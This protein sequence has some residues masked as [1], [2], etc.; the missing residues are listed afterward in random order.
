MPGRVIV[1]LT[2]DAGAGTFE[3]VDA[4]PGIDVA[5]ALGVP[6]LRVADLTGGES[7]AEAIGTIEDVPGVAFAEPDYLVTAS[8]TPSD[9]FFSLQWALSGANGIGVQR[10]WDRQTGSKS[11]KVAVV[12][13]GI[14]LAH[15]DLAPNLWVNAGESGARSDN[16]LDDDN[17]G[18]VDDVHGWDFVDN[19]ATPEDG[20]GHGTHVAG[21]IGASGNDATG[22]TGV[23]WRVSLM[24]VR[25][26]GSDGIGSTSTV[27]AAID[28]ARSH[29]ARVVN[30]S[31]GGPA[32]SLTLASMIHSTPD[33]LFTV[34]AGNEA[35]NT[36][37][38]P[39]YP[40]NLPYP[41]V[42][43][44][45]S[46]NSA[47][48]LSGF[49]NYGTRYVDLA[50][51]G[52]SIL[53]TVPGGYGYM[54]GTS[55]ASP[56]V[57]GAAALLA[58][59]APSASMAEITSAILTG[60]FRDSRLDGK[61]ASG[62]RLDVASALDILVPSTGPSGDPE[63]SPS[64]T[65]PDPGPSVDPSPLP[66]PTPTID[67]VPSETPPPAAGEHAIAVSFRLRRHM[68]GT[69]RVV[70]TDGSTDCPAEA[71]VTLRWNGYSVRSK[72]ADTEGHFMFRIPSR[73]GSYRVFVAGRDLGDFQTCAPA[74]SEVR[75]Y[76]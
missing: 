31:L 36:D 62:A 71:R 9:P 58:A 1:G 33:V 23:D 66:D 18:F 24:S 34:A 12:D 32:Y 26:L 59:A 39:E 5:S 55:M 45:A 17:D 6:K 73:K 56:Q 40:C 42:L 68:V 15:P 27:A 7:V 22:S 69:G 19:D 13:S 61:T 67:P 3:T 11:V 25:A 48:D 21:I 37:D 29:G 64:P 41:N 30:L 49:S 54:N 35:V 74:S 43:C 52:T 50:A 76:S 14:D 46:T 8:A 4:K 2:S 51:P 53:S 10:A 75:R 47:G 72:Q 70:T 63:P 44:V 20:H 57:A 60:A 16:G 28:F 38:S 65:V